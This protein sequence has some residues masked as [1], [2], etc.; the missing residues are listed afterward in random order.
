MNRVSGGILAVFFLMNAHAV[1]GSDGA[2]KITPK[3]YVVRAS[4]DTLVSRIDGYWNAL[5]Q[6]KKGQAAEYVAAANREKF[7]SSNFP[8][9]TNPHLKSLE[10]SADRKEAMVT[11]IVT[12]VTPFG[13]KIDWPVIDR[14]R[15]EKG[16]WYRNIPE[17]SR[18]IIPGVEMKADSAG[19][20]TEALKNEVRKLLIIENTVLDFGTVRSATPLPL[21]LKYTLGG[22]EPM[23]AIIN[24]PAGFGVEGGNDVMLNPGSHEL[25]ITVPTWQLDGVVHEHIGMTV[26]KLGATVPFDIEVTGNVYVPVSIAPK[27]LRFK[28][29]ENEKEVRIRNN[30]KSDLD[31][32]SMYSE[33]RQVM[34]QPLPA[35]VL[36]GQEIVLKVKLSKESASLKANQADNLAISFAKPVDGMNSLSLS[37]I[38]NAEDTGKN[39]GSIDAKDGIPPISAD[40]S[41]NCKAPASMK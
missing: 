28:K 15:F 3:A 40:K 20:D 7:Y 13:A 16:N 24:V 22:K 41:K 23:G 29:E 19:E 32:L 30:S 12:R 18:A 37:V 6:K 31:L 14:W 17:K 4:L 1:A 38:L 2:A 11:V 25:R 10:L 36:S 34:I 39:S 26:R 21:S 27:M 8:S 35:T 9:F 33:T 5:L